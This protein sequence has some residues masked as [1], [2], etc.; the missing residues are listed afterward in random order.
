MC[1]AFA[2]IDAA[3]VHGDAAA[4][5]VAIS[6]FSCYITA[7]SH[8]TCPHKA[9]LMVLCSSC[10]CCTMPCH[11]VLCC[12][13]LCCA[14]LCHAVFRFVILLVAHVPQPE[15]EYASLQSQVGYQFVMRWVNNHIYFMK[16]KSTL[17][18]RIL[19]QVQQLPF[20]NS[21][22]FVDQVINKTCRPVGYSPVT[23]P[24]QYRDFYNFCLF[25]LIKAS[26]ENKGDDLDNVLFDQPLV[27][28]FLQP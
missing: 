13:V 18:K 14:V 3:L 19:E 15:D 2:V 11:A 6:I 23:D 17:G 5:A 7:V 25:Q 4:Q 9:V 21:D 26:E 24:E 10:H 28:P 12:A 20:E 22:K 8:G 1:R 27:S 16:K